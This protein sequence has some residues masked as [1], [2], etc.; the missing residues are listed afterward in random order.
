MKTRGILWL[1]MATLL[2]APTWAAEPT[3]PGLN[4]THVLQE[5]SIRLTGSGSNVIRNGPGNSFAIF[6]VYPEGA[7]FVVIAKKNDWYNVRL[8]QTNT[9]WI[10]SSLCEEFDDM[11]DLEFRPNPRLFS[12]A[13]T[14]S[15]TRSE[16]RRVGKECRSR[17]SPYH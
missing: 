15:L 1:A 17:W 12:R 8:S 5:R 10:H 16:E 9:G 6:A 3:A 14:F 2:V 11:T 13:G 4:D 7:E